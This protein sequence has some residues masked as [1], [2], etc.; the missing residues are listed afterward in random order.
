M[1]R[2]TDKTEISHGD[3]LR[4]EGLLTIGRDLERQERQVVKSVEG[5]IGESD[6]NGLAMDAVYNDWSARQL[7]EQSGIK[8]VPPETKEA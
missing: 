3:Y 6:G 8:V 4:L 2:Y 1:G 7:L 5:I